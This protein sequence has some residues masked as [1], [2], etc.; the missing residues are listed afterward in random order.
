MRAP[1]LQRSRATS[2]R[3]GLGGPAHG[4]ALTG[5]TTVLLVGVGGTDVHPTNNVEIT[6]RVMSRPTCTTLHWEWDS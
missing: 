6:Q 4:D 1:E 5:G 3:M 2:S